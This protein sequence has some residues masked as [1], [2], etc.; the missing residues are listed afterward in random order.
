MQK[1]PRM[2]N[3]V[4][5]WTY[6]KKGRPRHISENSYTKKLSQD[7]TIAKGKLAP[8]WEVCIESSKLSEKT[9]PFS[10]T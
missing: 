3:Y 5:T 4:K 9:L 2:R 7:S 8:T 10:R 1:T 6:W